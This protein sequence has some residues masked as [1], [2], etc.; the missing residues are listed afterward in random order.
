MGQ[1]IHRFEIGHFCCT[2]IND[3]DNGARNVLLV[4]GEQRVLIDTGV[5][6]HNPDNPGRL[7]AR[8]AEAGVDALSIDAVVLSHADFDHIGGATDGSQLS[9]SDAEH[10]I[11][12]AEV[13]FWKDRP[14]RLVP[15]PL[16]DEVFRSRVNAVPPIALDAVRRGRLHLVN[17]GAE[18][19]RG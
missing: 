12:R 18:V 15:S 1:Y 11:L 3:A 7:M 6:A 19:A 9:F 5:G 10:N 13:E 16:Y 2:A 8:L 4:E 17:D 14:V